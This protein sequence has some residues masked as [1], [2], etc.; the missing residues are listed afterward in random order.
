MSATR[1]LLKIL[2][3]TFFFKI[4][5]Q[6]H[7]VMEKPPQVYIWLCSWQVFSDVLTSRL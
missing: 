3:S 4:L 1:I 5:V 6:L 2:V 7:A